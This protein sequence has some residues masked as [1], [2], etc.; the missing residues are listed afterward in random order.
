MKQNFLKLPAWLRTNVFY[1]A[2]L[3]LDSTEPVKQQSDCIRVHPYDANLISSD[4]GNGKHVVMLDLDVEHLYVE[5]STE[6][7]G[8]LYITADLDY[9][10]LVE[11]L[12][13]LVK[14]GIVQEGIYN[15]LLERKHLNLR[16]PGQIKYSQDDLGLE[17]IK[18]V[19]GIE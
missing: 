8:H 7:H 10:D 6:G 1:R 9:E 5:S 15:T 3:E 16:L 17:E 4:K 19:K 18:K 13:P 2:K 14:H 12:E 11:I